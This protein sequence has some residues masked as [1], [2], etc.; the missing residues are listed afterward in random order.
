MRKSLNL[1]YKFLKKQKLNDPFFQRCEFSESGKRDKISRHP[2]IAAIVMLAFSLGLFL[3]SAS[4]HKKIESI[5]DPENEW[6]LFLQKMETRRSNVKSV[7]GFLKGM[8]IEAKKS[9][10]IKGAY[11]AST[12]DKIR[13]D[14]FNPLGSLMFSWSISESSG[15]LRFPSE[16]RFYVCTE[17]C[18][19]IPLPFGD[20]TS[21]RLIDALLAL[22]PSEISG[23]GDVLGPLNGNTYKVKSAAGDSAEYILRLEGATGRLLEIVYPT[24]QKGSWTVEYLEYQQAAQMELPRSLNISHSSSSAVLNIKNRISSINSPVDDEF[25]PDD[26]FSESLRV[27][28]NEREWNTLMRR[29]SEGWFN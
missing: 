8:Y 26:S 6:I 28:L 10:R 20:I 2:G 4:C 25:L 3:L 29:V 7:R 12:P 19:L 22:P 16:K 18:E 9:R 15:F 14:G 13:L 23:D 24:G 21:K 5:P 1:K 11:A 27:E 17:N